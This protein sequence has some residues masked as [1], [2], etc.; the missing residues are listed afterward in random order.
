MKRAALAACAAVLLLPCGGAAARPWSEIRLLGEASLC[1]NP[2]A[3]PYA[4][5]QPG[6]P[7]FQIEIA[8]AL[9]Q[10]LGVR[11][12]VEWIVPRM[13]AA[14]VDCDLLM[15]SIAVPGV[16]PPSLRLS[17]PYHRSGVSLAFGPGREPVPSY[18]ELKAGTRVGVIM[19]SL[20]SLVVSRTPATMVPFG[21][22]DDMLEAV[23]RGE[24]V[25]GAASAAAVGYFNLQHPGAPL[26]LV[27]AED[28]E[29]ELRWP[30]AVGLRRADDLLVENVNAA[31]AQLL[32]DGT[33]AAIYAKYGVGHRAPGAAQP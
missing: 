19:N 11:L 8:R 22:E 1:S 16:Q 27:H 31:L 33:I 7:G 26:T 3:L 12:R 23:A 4:S 18:R 28:S 30:V 13:R 29:A 14:T 2:N 32:A 25:A 17:I 15:D 24:V 6:A 20:A 21:F 9:A 10:R 5:N